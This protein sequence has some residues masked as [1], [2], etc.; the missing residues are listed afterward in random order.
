MTLSCLANQIRKPFDERFFN[1][2]DELGGNFKFNIDM[3]SGKPLGSSRP[4]DCLQRYGVL[5]KL[6]LLYS[7]D[8]RF[9]WWWTEE[10]L[11][12]GIS[13]TCGTWAEKPPR[14]TER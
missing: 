12:Y 4:L 11:R 10:E 9:E 14:C 13:Y 3:N 6:N 5:T 8:A 1:A 7:M 2:A